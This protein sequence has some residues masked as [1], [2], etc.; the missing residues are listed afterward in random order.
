MDFFET[1]ILSDHREC[2]TLSLL[3]FLKL[4]PMDF[5]CGS[6]RHASSC[7]WY[8]CL[9]VNIVKGLATNLFYNFLY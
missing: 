7:V 1:F 6:M 2:T 8:A 5:Q 9:I 4:I 3:K